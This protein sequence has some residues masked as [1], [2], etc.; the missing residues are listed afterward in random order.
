[1]GSGEWGSIAS[2]LRLTR[3]ESEVVVLLFLGNTRNA[4]ARILSIKPSTV[5]QYM[6]QVHEK[7]GV[8]DRVTLVLSIIECRDELRE[9]EFDATTRTDSNAR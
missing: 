7:L 5:R 2:R 9:Q 6:E 4:I 1:M 8:Q 3:R